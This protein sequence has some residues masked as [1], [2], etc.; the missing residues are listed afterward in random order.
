MWPMFNAMSSSSLSTTTVPSRRTKTDYEGVM[1]VLSPIFGYWPRSSSFTSKKWVI[2]SSITIRPPGTR[3]VIR[4]DTQVHACSHRDYAQGACAPGT[5]LSTSD[6]T[7]RT[8]RAT[9]AAFFIVVVV[10][11]LTATQMLVAA[12]FDGALSLAFRD[13]CTTVHEE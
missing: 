6:S 12:R 13:P 4:G 2:A 10:A 7:W 1:K 5:P 9:R 8:S 3:I 11:L